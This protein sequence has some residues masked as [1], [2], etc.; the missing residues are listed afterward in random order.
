MTDPKKKIPWEDAL[1]SAAGIAADREQSAYTDTPNHT[2]SDRH[3]E[4]I[5]T[6]FAAAENARDARE[7][8][9][10]RMRRV[11]RY[12]AVACACF[13]V[14]I[15]LTLSIS[16][17]REAIWKSMVTWFDNHMELKHDNT[18]AAPDRIEVVYTPA[19]LPEGYTGVEILM[20]S[21]GMYVAEYYQGEDIDAAAEAGHIIGYDQ[22]TLDGLTAVNNE[23]CTIE[24]CEISGYPG[25]FITYDPDWGCLRSVYWDDGQYAYSL[26]IEDNRISDG[27]ILKIAESLRVNEKL[28]EE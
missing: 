3:T 23:H 18:E 28:P 9:R 4:Q 26:R 1:H 7:K 2:F 13:A 21:P 25:I 16:A 15:C 19:Y 20:D 11:Q 12:A 8:K 17:V 27:E 14:T 24:D 22:M 6:I 10:A 5:E